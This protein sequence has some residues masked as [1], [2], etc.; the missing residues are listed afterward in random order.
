MKRL[1]IAIAAF[2][3][4][5]CGN[6]LVI[7]TLQQ[8]SVSQ[9]TSCNADHIEVIEHK[10]NDED[11]SATWTALCQGRTYSC[12]RAAGTANNLENADVSCTEMESQMPE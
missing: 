2:G 8:Q 11:G 12:Q 10:I 5:A 1:V 9:I 6:P 4:F 7:Q 3:L